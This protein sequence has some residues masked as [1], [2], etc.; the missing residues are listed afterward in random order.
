METSPEDEQKK[1][2]QGVGPIAGI[3]IIVAL[4]LLGG[5]YFFLSRAEQNQ[6]NTPSG[7]QASLQ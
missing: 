3:I 6:Q 1:Q 7:E 5:I 4:L 2:E